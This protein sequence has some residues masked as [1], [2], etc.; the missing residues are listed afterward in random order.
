MALTVGS[1]AASGFLIGSGV[2]LIAAAAT[3]AARGATV[4]G[5]T[6]IGV[7]GIIEVI[8][9]MLELEQKSGGS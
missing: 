2:G 9:E 5:V 4:A 1:S 6:S 8:P 3:G 7:G